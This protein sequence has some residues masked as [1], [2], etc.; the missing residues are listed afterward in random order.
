MYFFFQ[1]LKFA[2]IS[3]RE[4]VYDSKSRKS[5]MFIISSIIY[6]IQLVTRS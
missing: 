6:K 5:R 3:C 2:A 4:N 1:E